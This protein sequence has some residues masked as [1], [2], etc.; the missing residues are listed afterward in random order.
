M[1]DKIST[2]GVKL[3]R[4]SIAIANE[5]LGLRNIQGVNISRPAIDATTHDD[6]YRSKVAGL[7]EAEEVV[8]T[9]ALDPQDSQHGTFLTEIA[10]DTPSTAARAWVITYPSNAAGTKKA[11]WTF[12]AHNGR[13]NEGEKN[14]DGLLEIE[15]SLIVTGEP[16]YDADDTTVPA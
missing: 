5:V 16:V 7:F 11:S 8:I 12:N 10:G 13:W 14:V 2:Y 4:T 9:L 3:Y 6:T 15:F 1:P